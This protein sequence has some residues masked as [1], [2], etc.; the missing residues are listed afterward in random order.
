M[1]SSSFFSGNI[2]ET[3]TEITRIEPTIPSEIGDGI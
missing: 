2:I 1:E 3:N